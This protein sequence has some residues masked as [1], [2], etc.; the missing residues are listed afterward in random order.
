[1][2]YNP[3]RTQRMLSEHRGFKCHVFH[4]RCIMQICQKVFIE[5]NKAHHVVPHD[6]FLWHCRYKVPKKTPK[7]YMKKG[8]GE[9]ILKGLCPPCHKQK[10]PNP[11]KAG[12]MKKRDNPPNSQV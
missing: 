11:P 10:K 2:I 3:N 1:M 9:K 12:A 4:S 8:D 5:D 6:E 7:E